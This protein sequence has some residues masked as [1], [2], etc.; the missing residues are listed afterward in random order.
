M[1]LIEEEKS[2]K[3][4]APTSSVS[5]SDR[6]SLDRPTRL[7]ALKELLRLGGNGDYRPF[8]TTAPVMLAFLITVV[9]CFVLLQN[10]VNSGSPLDSREKHSLKKRT[11]AF[12]IEERV[13]LQGV[14]VFFASNESENTVGGSVSI[15]TKHVSRSSTPEDGPKCEHQVDLRYLW[16]AYTSENNIGSFA[17]Q[18]P[19]LD[20]IPYCSR[21]NCGSFAFD[22]QANWCEYY[23]SSFDGDAPGAIYDANT[24]PDSDDFF[25]YEPNCTMS[26]PAPSI[27]SVGLSITPP[28]TSS[29]SLPSRTTTTPVLDDLTTG[30]GSF[31]STSISANSVTAAYMFPTETEN[32][33]IISQNTSSTTSSG[34]RSLTVLYTTITPHFTSLSRTFSVS[35]TPASYITLSSTTAGHITLSRT[36]ASHTTLSSTTASYITLST[37]SNRGYV[38]FI[39]PLEQTTLIATVSSHSMI[40]SNQSEHGG[41][42]TTSH[43]N[44]E[45]PLFSST[46]LTLPKT[47]PDLMTSNSRTASTFIVTSSDGGETVAV[48]EHSTNTIVAS[49][50]NPT[51]STSAVI[52]IIS[53]STT[54]TT[55]SGQNLNSSFSAAIVASTSPSPSPS[56]LTFASNNQDPTPGTTNIFPVPVASSAQATSSTDGNFTESASASPNMITSSQVIAVT[57][58]PSSLTSHSGESS[59]SHISSLSEAVTDPSSE[60]YGPTSSEVTQSSSS[61]Y[62]TPVEP[63]TSIVPEPVTPTQEGD[64]DTDGDGESGL[65]DDDDGDNTTSDPADSA[66]NTADNTGRG[67]DTGDNNP[68]TAALDVTVGPHFLQRKEWLPGQPG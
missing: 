36:T 4:S 33:Q 58:Q 45:P 59:T 53:S 56:T 44:Q 50:Q 54:G 37:E 3:P 42:S 52:A 67:D 61:L 5:S 1:G 6:E 48:P 12:I 34:T 38:T 30:N 13:D 51:S 7:E 28:S 62:L 63:V 66:D 46:T 27:S 31:T 64:T 60:S 65:A 49:S 2:T 21:I 10:I 11:E 20:C 55:P 23:M 29:A 26:T 32:S 68:D 19:I 47:N 17:A 16:W 43:P 22:P 25:I 57:S 24:F 39:S 40:M 9:L 35:N 14:N 41:K 15:L 8:T 18:D